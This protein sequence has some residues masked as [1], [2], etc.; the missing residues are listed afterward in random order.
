[1]RQ[2]QVKFIQ[3]IS[4]RP[5][6]IRR[7]LTARTRGRHTQTPDVRFVFVNA[8]LGQTSLRVLLSTVSLTP[9]TALYFTEFIQ[10]S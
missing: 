4:G 10:P 8:A 5:L 6:A 3:F 2:T 7:N 9:V 1:M